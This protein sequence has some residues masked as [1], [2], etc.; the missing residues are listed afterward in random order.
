VSF[1]LDALLATYCLGL[2]LALVRLRRRL[3]TLEARPQTPPAPAPEPPSKPPPTLA[4]RP[5]RLRYAPPGWGLEVARAVPPEEARLPMAEDPATRILDPPPIVHERTPNPTD[6]DYFI[7][8]P[9]F[10][11]RQL[12]ALWHQTPDGG[13]VR[14]SPANPDARITFFDETPQTQPENPSDPT[15]NAWQRLTRDDE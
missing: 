8:E 4:A 12:E 9:P 14:S 2:T 7:P 1:S 3:N 15:P 13:I 6:P 10:S 11:S 5:Q